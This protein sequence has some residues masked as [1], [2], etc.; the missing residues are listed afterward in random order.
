MCVVG[1][2]MCVCVRLRPKSAHYGMRRDGMMIRMRS[3]LNAIR[4]P[5]YGIMRIQRHCYTTA[6]DV[7]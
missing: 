6:R 3:E 1:V 2:C 4:L 5:Y 7:N